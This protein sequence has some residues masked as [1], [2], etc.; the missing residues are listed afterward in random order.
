MN[1]F[2]D[3]DLVQEKQFDDVVI[4]KDNQRKGIEVGGETSR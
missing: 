3:L 2:I 1:V 4:K